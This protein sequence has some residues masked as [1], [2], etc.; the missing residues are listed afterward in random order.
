MELS[1][2][3]FNRLPGFTSSPPGYERVFLRYL[4]AA[5][6]GGSLSLLL[7]LLAVRWSSPDGLLGPLAK[8]EIYLISL[9]FLYWSALLILAIAAFIVMVM[10]GPAY[11]ADAYPLPDADSPDTGEQ[12]SKKPL[13]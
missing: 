11:V 8:A 12:K 3:L 4:P 6:I 5:G 7:A 2:E 13:D 9:F 1:M 10:K